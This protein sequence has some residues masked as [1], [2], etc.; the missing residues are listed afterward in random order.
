MAGHAHRL[1][2]LRLNREPMN[3]AIHAVH[4]HVVKSGWLTLRRGSRW[5]R[6]SDIGRTSVV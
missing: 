1:M 5:T 6:F 2:A 4:Q 3:E